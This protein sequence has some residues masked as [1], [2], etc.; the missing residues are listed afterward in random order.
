[1]SRRRWRRLL[2]ASRA[3]RREERAK[4]GETVFLLE[5]NVKR[6]LGGLRDLQ[7]VRWVGFT[8]YGDNDY[9]GLAQ[10][11]WIAR[12]EQRRLREAWLRSG[13]GDAP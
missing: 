9:D 8:R 2:A 6:S 10:G 1:M 13:T 11:G 5:P 3:A 7:L 4:Y 12:E